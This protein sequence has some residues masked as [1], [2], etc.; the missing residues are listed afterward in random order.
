MQK[1]PSFATDPKNV[2]A[3]VHGMMMTALE[4]AVPEVVGWMPSH[5]TYADLEL[6]MARKSDGTLVNVQDLEANGLAGFLAKKGVEHYR[7]HRSEVRAWVVQMERAKA[8][9]KWIG[10]ASHAANELAE[11]PFK[12]S[13]ASRWRADAAKRA[14][15]N[16]KCGADGR[17]K[18]GK[19]GR[20]IIE[21]GNGGHEVVKAATGRGWLCVTCRRRTIK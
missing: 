2:L 11:Y 20:V 12:D 1:G 14:K 8:R 19:G 13:E 15:A 4:D 5:L 21:P 9:A 18:K 16:A 7:V 6:R 17:R 3:R 10:I